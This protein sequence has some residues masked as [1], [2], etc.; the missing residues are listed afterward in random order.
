MKRYNVV[1][2]D[3]RLYMERMYAR[4]IL[5]G[6]GEVVDK[7]MQWL[8][9]TEAKEFFF[10]QRGSLS[11]FM[12]TSGI[13]SEWQNII[14]ERATHGVDITTQIY[15][16]ARQLNTT[17][18]LP[19]YTEQERNI[20]N[21]VCD[22]TYELIRNVSDDQVR[23]IRQRLLRDYA[24]G[25]NP[26]QTSLREVQLEPINGWTPEQRAV[27]IARTESARAINSGALGQYLSDGIEYVTLLVSSDCDECLAYA[28][29]P[30]TG[31]EIRTPITDVLDEPVIHPNCR[32]AW[33]PATDTRVQ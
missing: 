17:G 8:E 6:F 18:T 11:R 2:S 9:T 29:D 14:E 23:G 7:T 33:V 12:K 16:Y 27:V 3:R 13:Q 22:N 19:R 5:D 25:T 20:F 26:R 31:E 21:K 28:Q 15:E 24:E 1:P 10:E 32:C 30:N 4:N